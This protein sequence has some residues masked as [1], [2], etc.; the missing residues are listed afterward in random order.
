MLFNMLNL[1]KLYLDGIKVKANASKLKV[2]L[3]KNIKNMEILMLS[4][5]F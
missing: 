1:N 3:K 4:Q 5:K 2:L